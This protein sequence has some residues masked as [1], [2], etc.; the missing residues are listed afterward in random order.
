M[1]A[2]KCVPK[3]SGSNVTFVAFIGFSPLCVSDDRGTDQ[4]GMK[5]GGGHCTVAHTGDSWGQGWPSC[6][7]TTH[8]IVHCVVYWDVHCAMCC[9]VFCGVHCVV[10]YALCGT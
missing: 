8:C 7:L 6:I 2:L 4:K 1:G 9:I 5:R 10:Q 3:L